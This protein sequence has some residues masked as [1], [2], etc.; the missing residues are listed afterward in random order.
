MLQI[1]LE[2][3]ALRVHAT[4]GAKRVAVGGQHDGALRVSV[5]APADQGR[6]NQAIIKALAKA[7]GIKPRQIELVSGN[8]H[9][10][11]VFRISQPPSELSAR[12]EQLAKVE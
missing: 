6:A 4:P 11:K 5:T 1:S 3:A 2:Q 9:R 10:R 7:L 12:V 8:I